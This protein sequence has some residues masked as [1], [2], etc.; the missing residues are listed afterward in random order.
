MFQIFILHYIPDFILHFVSEFHSLNTL[1]KNITQNLYT[2]ITFLLHIINHIHIKTLYGSTALFM[3]QVAHILKY[4]SKSHSLKSFFGKYNLIPLLNFHLTL[5][6][7]FS[8]TKHVIQKHYIKIFIIKLHSY[9][10]IGCTH[11]K[12]LY[13]N[14]AL[15]YV[16]GSMYYKNTIKGN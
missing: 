13:S 6:F 10:I 2:K 11:T 4:F 8:F 1:Y 7:R 15:F 9:Y 5:C 16:A 14:T 3:S 12:T